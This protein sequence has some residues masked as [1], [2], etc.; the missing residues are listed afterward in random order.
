MRF[1]K[2]LADSR[3]GAPCRSMKPALLPGELPLPLPDPLGV[4]VVA[5]AADPAETNLLKEQV[6]IDVA[7]VLVARRSLH[8]RSSRGVF[9][10]GLDAA[11]QACEDAVPAEAL[12]HIKPFGSVIVVGHSSATVAP[13]LPSN[14]ALHSVDIASLVQARPDL[15]VTL[16]AEATTAFEHIPISGLEISVRDV[17]EIAEALRLVNT[18]VHAKA[19]LQVDPDSILHV[20]PAA[21][22]DAWANENATYVMAGGLGDIGQRFLVLMAKGGAKHL[23][24]I[25]RRI[26]DPDT[27][28]ALQAKL[29]AIRPG[30]RLCTLQGD[31]SSEFSVQRAAA[32]LSR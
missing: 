17:A 14:V 6:G 21:K 26:V 19:V 29:E 25:S 12:A 9:A 3:V 11:I 16:V 31:V 4:R 5:T 22:P 13:K 27:Y 15:T 10:D 23:A 32:K 28:R 18:G 1:V 7:D 8:R 20:V 2:W 24:T 30:I